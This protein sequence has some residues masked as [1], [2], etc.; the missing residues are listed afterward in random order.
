METVY[1]LL[2]LCEGNPLVT[3]HYDITVMMLR[4]YPP[5]VIPWDFT[6]TLR[7]KQNCRHFASHILKRI[8]VNE[9]GWISMK[10]SVNIIP[11]G[12]VDNTSAS[13]QVKA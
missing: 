2:A 3:V 4:K 9:N 6:I 7:P 5:S 8:F 10:M 11:N 12:P 13:V 1:A